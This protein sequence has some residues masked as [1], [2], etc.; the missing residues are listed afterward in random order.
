MCRRTTIKC[1]LPGRAICVGAL[2]AGGG[3][4]RQVRRPRRLRR[5]GAPIANDTALTCS[6][7]RHLIRWARGRTR[8]PPHRQL[9]TPDETDP[10]I[11]LHGTSAEETPLA[12]IYCP[13]TGHY[14][15]RLA[16]PSTDTW[17]L[18]KTTAEQRSFLGTAG[19]LVTITS[20]AE[21]AFLFESVLPGSPSDEIFIGAYQDRSAP[22]YSEPAGG[23]RWI[24]GEPWEWTNWG[25]G[26]PNNWNP[27][28]L[29][30]EDYGA[31]W[32]LTDPE[33]L[34]LSGTWNDLPQ[35][36]WGCLT[37]IVEYDVPEPGTLMLL[38]VGGIVLAQRRARRRYHC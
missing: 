33:L 29:V 16:W 2:R 5:V 8:P 35:H 23:W 34:Y 15:E 19:H 13:A 27:H 18:A 12:P 32:W 25:S 1:P 6:A 24:T 36:S 22:D 37:F 17:D 3:V 28:H 20:P 21:N 14:Y 10:G 9:A 4:V 26:E 38:A 30:E 31:I 7:P 11:M